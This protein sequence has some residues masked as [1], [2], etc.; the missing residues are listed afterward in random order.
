MASKRA[1]APTIRRMR[2][3]AAG[4]A[5]VSIVLAAA[6]LA[7]VPA[8]AQSTLAE[9]L[10]GFSGNSDKPI[11]IESDS[12]EVRDKEQIA[13]FTGNVRVVQ[14]DVTLKTKVLKVWYE[15][16]MGAAGQQQIRKLDAEGKV[17]VTTKDQTTTGE[18]ASFDMKTQIITMTGDVVLSQ[19]KNVL[20]GDRLVVDLN[21]GRS[22][23]EANGR[24]SGSFV[25][26]PAGEK[27]KGQ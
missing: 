19:G 25:S 7:V 1:S 21:T 13:I 5:I 24:V 15:G 27:G 23:L 4:A 2:M 22:H 20:K 18:R 14:G 26:K 3:Q 10:S 16:K 11:N 12:L 9:S 6:G 17:L 8:A